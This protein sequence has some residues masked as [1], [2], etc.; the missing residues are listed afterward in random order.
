MSAPPAGPDRAAPAEVV[1][2][3]DGRPRS[4]RYDDIYFAADGLAESRTVFLRGCGLPEAWSSRTRFTVAELG[5]G[6]GLNI[7][8]LLRLW[9]DTRPLGA[10]LHMFSLEAHPLADAEAARALEAFPEIA[11]LAAPLLA[12]WPGGAR[13]FE[14]Y[15]WPELGA[16]LDVAT[17][18]A[19]EALSGWGGPAD[20][21]FLDGFAPSRNPEMWRPEVLDL[22]RARSAPGARLATFTVA[23]AVRR[24]LAERGWTLTRAPGHGGKRERLEGRLPGPALGDPQPP[25]VAVIGGGIAGA[26]LARAFARLGVTCTVIDPAPASGASGNPAALVSPRLDVGGGPAARLYA[27]AFT[28]A[29]ELYTTEAPAAVAA[30]GALRLPSGA[31]DDTRFE[32]L[33]RSDLFRPGALT[34]I[35]GETASARLGA[36]TDPALWMGDALTLD[37]SAVIEVWLSGARRLAATFTG[38]DDRTSFQLLHGESGVL[39]EVDIVCMANGFAAWRW[40]EDGLLEAVRG[41]VSWTDAAALPG[42]PAS[43]GGY[44][45][46]FPTGGVL[47][48]ATHARGSENR[49]KSDADDTTNLATLAER[50]PGLAASIAEAPLQSRASIRAATPDRL[51]LAGPIPGY[52]GQFVLSGL[53]GRGF[54]TAPLLAEHVAALALGA[55]S[56]L[57]RD[58]A[59]AVDPNRFE[60]RARRSGR[61]KL[62]PALFFDRDGVLNQDIGY[63]YRVE[64]LRWTPG[65]REAVRRVND[66]GW[67]AFVVT[68][69]SGVARGL[70]SLMQM[71]GFHLAMLK[72]LEEIGARIDAFYS[73]PFHADAVA[74]EWRHPDHP[75]R[76]PNPGML[77]RAM[78]EHRV[79]SARSVM[80]GD[81]PTDMEAARRAGV[82]GVLYEGGDLSELVAGILGASK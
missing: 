9:R 58:L 42:A 7:L 38:A 41:Q 66:A 30:R 28:R 69:Q 75:D 45:I 31:R 1:W 14:R 59:E 60:M 40:L 43:W 3:E 77:L 56:P 52:P 71:D 32:A 61:V 49:T 39:G 13:G 51:P 48:G 53:G 29:V 6:T 11:D 76:K 4:A 81:K 23:G 27:Q 82:R 18:E 25:R 37:P 8:A 12:R 65:A 17:G 67:F 70:Y 20:A 44:A 16:I 73:C 36:L 26:S 22:I 50:L 80:I 79:D 10:R 33:A 5:F 57:P 46:P 47:F 78:A 74:P 68:N 21:W 24:G 19:A 34:L 35:D 64:D 55:P 72:D 62:R 54:T 63:P 2:S 15:G